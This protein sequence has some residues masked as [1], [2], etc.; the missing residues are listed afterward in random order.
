MKRYSWSLLMVIVAASIASASAQTANTP[1]TLT[2]CLTAAQTYVQ[3]QY[4]AA[5]KGGERPNYAEIEKQKVELARTCAAKFTIEGI[6]DQSLMK[7]AALYAEAKQ[8]AQ[9]TA[10]IKKY[11]AIKNL[12]E[13]DRATALVQAVR[14]S[15]A[16]SMSDEKTRQID[17]YVRQLDALSE[18]VN[19]QKFDAHFQLCRYYRGV[20]IDEQIIAHGER[21]LALMPKL[22]PE[23]AAK[24]RPRMASIYTS[25]AEV[26]AGREQIDAAIAILK[27]GQVELKDETSTPYAQ[28]ALATTIERYSLVGRPAPKIEGQHWINAPASTKQAELQGQ[29]TLMQF[30]AHWCGPCR[31]S[32]PNMLTLHNRYGQKGLQVLF[33]TQLYGFFENQQDLTPEAEIA[34]DQKY[35]TEHHGLPF[36]VAIQRVAPRTANAQLPAEETN[37]TRYFVGGIPQIMVIDKKGIVRLIMIG[38]DPANDARMTRLLERLLAEPGPE[39]KKDTMR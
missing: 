11:L 5:R 9:A 26:Y 35:Y 31:K 21:V 25:L 20:D 36:K 13:A 8:P 2:E 18:A 4:D 38:W 30:T 29:V 33:A 6:E 32:Y 3:T 34:A 22:S 37:E 1:Q 16:P 7:L 39:N 12:A 24:L 15:L 19:R 28:K 27:R 14:L 23:D 17:E 10:A